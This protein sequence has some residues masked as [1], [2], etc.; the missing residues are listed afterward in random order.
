MPILYLVFNGNE[1]TGVQDVSVL[2]NIF[3]DLLVAKLLIAKPKFSYTECTYLNV[4][5][6][7]PFNDNSTFSET[8]DH[9]V[10]WSFIVYSEF[11][12]FRSI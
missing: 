2:N 11:S 10:E 4:D 5:V 3:T 8:W 12:Q 7:V 1:V 9:M 6:R